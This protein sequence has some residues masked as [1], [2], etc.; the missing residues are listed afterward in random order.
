VWLSHDMRGY[1]GIESLTY[2]AFAR[3]MEQVD[4]G[5]LIVNVGKES[6]PKDGSG[7]RDLNV[8]DSYDEGFKL[9]QANL[10]ELVKNNSNPPPASSSA[11]ESPTTYSYVYL[12][13]QPFINCFFLPEK[14]AADSKQAS[15]SESQAYLQ[16]ILL[17]SDPAHQLVHNTVTQ[18]I[19]A[20]W[21]DLWDEYD[22]VEDV[23][24]ETLR[25]GVEVIG[26]EYIA[27]RMGWNKHERSTEATEADDASYATIEKPSEF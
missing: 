5:D 13:I 24:A 15:N 22:W 10:D 9:A 19:P 25:M 26:Q 2:R 3:V 14:A 23:V 4:G 12:R 27:A 1:E 6:R 20:S 7:S 21:L 17:L 11:I 18:T 16:F 8:A